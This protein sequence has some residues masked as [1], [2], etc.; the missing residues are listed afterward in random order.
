MP[1]YYKL[2]HKNDVCGVLSIDTENGSLLDYETT[3]EETAPF[4]GN[5]NKSLMK[6][7][8]E[9]RAVP[10]S[11]KAMQE[12]IRNAGCFTS[13][14]YLAKNLAL[15]LTDMYWICPEE[16]GLKWD[17]VN[18]YH[19]TPGYLN[20]KLPYHNASSYDPNASLG[21]QMEKYWDVTYDTPKLVK[22]AYKEYG[23]QAVNE[24][25]ATYIHKLQGEPFPYVKYE[26]SRTKDGGMQ[27]TCDAFTNESVEFI[28]ALEILDSQKNANSISLYDAYIEIC[29]AHGIDTEYIR[30]YMDYLT[31]TDFAISNTDEH[32]MNFG[33]LRNPDTM[34]FTGP[35]PIFDSGNSMF[36][37]DDRTKP[38]KRHEL[39]ERKITAIHDREENMLKHITNRHIVK[40]DLLPSPQETEEF[41]V[42]YGI[43]EPKAHFISGSYGQK[44]RLLHDYQKGKTISLYLEKKRESK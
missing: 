26:A 24:V 4:L 5:A 35:S 27:C 30:D 7:W 14:E 29:S 6:R 8:W 32:L 13:K 42:K 28:P 36:F 25:F 11:R 33:V 43:P 9:A 16:M 37:S 20:H 34:K 23:Q 44:I 41:F 22:T 1:D 38:Y 39:L 31:L 18:L 17:D 10:A 3:R 40:E 19:N 15:S 2:M 21:G 12:I